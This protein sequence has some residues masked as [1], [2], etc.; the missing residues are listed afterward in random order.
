[1]TKN[2]GHK[3]LSR[4]VGEESDHVT[5]TEHE[6]VVVAHVKNFVSIVRIVVVVVV[7]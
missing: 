5:D 7:V 2:G 4:I 3:I 1:M 6:Q